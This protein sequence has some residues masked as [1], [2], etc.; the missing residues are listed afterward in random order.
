MATKRRRFWL[1]AIQTYEPDC[2]PALPSLPVF[3]P[4]DKRRLLLLR[5]ADGLEQRG[6]N[7]QIVLQTR[8]IARQLSR[9]LDTRF[10][11]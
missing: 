9:R 5:I 8:Q 7:P 10:P 2:W 1:P 4:P 11:L 3:L 6:V